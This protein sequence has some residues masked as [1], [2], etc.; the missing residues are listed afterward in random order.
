VIAL[1]VLAAV[2]EVA[3]LLIIGFISLVAIGVALM[4]CIAVVAEVFGR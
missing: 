2:A 4:A 3:F 1:E